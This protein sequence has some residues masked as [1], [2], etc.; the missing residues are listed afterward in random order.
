[1]KDSRDE[2]LD[3]RDARADAAI[4]GASGYLELARRVRE[5]NPRAFATPKGDQE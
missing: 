2:Y 3:D 4:L 5:D 1:M